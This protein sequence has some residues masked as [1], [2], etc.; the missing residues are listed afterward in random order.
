MDLQKM[1]MDT[2]QQSLKVA[3]SSLGKMSAE[4]VVDVRT[5]LD[6]LNAEANGLLSFE[7]GD[8][9]TAPGHV[10]IRYKHKDGAEGVFFVAENFDEDGRKMT[11]NDYGQNGLYDV[12]DETDL[13]YLCE[14]IVTHAARQIAQNDVANM[15][16]TSNRLVLRLALAQ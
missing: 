14:A 2:Y 11:F 7:L 3:Q 4:F 9:S 1:F 16:K 8:A 13:A 15:Q 10:N 5:L 6:H 12:N